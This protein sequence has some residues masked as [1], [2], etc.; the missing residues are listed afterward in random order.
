MTNISFEISSL[1]RRLLSVCTIK[2]VM[3]ATAESCTGGMIAAAL[4]D[5]AGSSTAFERGFIT[6]SNDAKREMLG[7]NQATLD[8][9]G[10]VSREVAIEMVVGALLRSNAHLA[11]GVTGVAGPDGGS[12]AK[13]VGLVHVAVKY[14]D[15]VEH[16]KLLFSDQSRAEIRENTVKAALQ[17]CVGI[18]S[19]ARASDT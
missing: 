9:H 18:V 15:V 7:V 14:G 11:V 4:T 1:S 16:E 2:S 17:M 12:T 19:E 13:P 10:A 6:Y 5:V 3:I 8:A